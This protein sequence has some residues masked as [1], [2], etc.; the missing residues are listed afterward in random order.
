MSPTTAN[1]VVGSTIRFHSYSADASGNETSRADP[2]GF[3]SSSPSGVICNG[4]YS[5]ATDQAMDCGAN[6]AGSYVVTFQDG[7]GLFAAVTLTVSAAA[8]STACNS[9]NFAG[10]AACYLQNLFTAAL[11]LPGALLQ[12]LY[13]MAFV[14]K[15]GRSSIDF[16]VL[17]GLYPSV[18][19]RSGQAPTLPAIGR[20]MPFP[21]SIPFDVVLILEQFLTQSAVAPTVPYDFNMT[22]RGVHLINYHG[23]I[24]LSDVLTDDFMSMVRNVELALFIIVFVMQTKRFMEFYEGIL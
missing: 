2:I 20:C 21:F 10:D 18:A 9:G 5:E 3:F 15:S 22:V 13:D 23:V 1:T 7:S 8:A 16:S 14:S 19:C 11:N 12:G 4:P 17:N 6:A 24:I